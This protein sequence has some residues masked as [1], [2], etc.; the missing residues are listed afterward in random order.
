VTV[1][2]EGTSDPT[3]DEMVVQVHDGRW[4][5]AQGKVAIQFINVE[6]N[7]HGNPKNSLEDHWNRKKPKI[8]LLRIFLGETAQFLD[9][10]VIGVENAI[11]DISTF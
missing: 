6:L 3:I 11:D 8:N 1:G 10:V 9:Q 7:G 4:G 2:A 5:N